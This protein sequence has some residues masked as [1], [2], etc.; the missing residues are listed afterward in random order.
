MQ[1]LNY[2]NVYFSVPLLLGSLSSRSDS[3]KV[4]A[5]LSG[6][7]KIE[8]SDGAGGFNNPTIND[9]LSSVLK[10]IHRIINKIIVK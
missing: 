5:S 4:K 10:L 1:I 2:L 7:I 9:R 8:S 3:S 6:V